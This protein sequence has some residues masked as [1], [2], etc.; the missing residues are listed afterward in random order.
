MTPPSYNELI[1]ILFLVSYQSRQYNDSQDMLFRNESQ[2]FITKQ[3]H[4]RGYLFEIKGF[5]LSCHILRVFR[6]LVYHQH[7]NI[8]RSL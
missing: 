3:I 6:S 5:L 7:V 8:L 2:I 1:V 4:D